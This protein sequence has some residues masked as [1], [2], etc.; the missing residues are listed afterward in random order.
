MKNRIMS[1]TDTS[2]YDVRLEIQPNLGT[3][4]TQ[5][6]QATRPRNELHKPDTSG[7]NNE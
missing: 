2:H 6:T 4:Q 7:L 1:K 5:V 3:A